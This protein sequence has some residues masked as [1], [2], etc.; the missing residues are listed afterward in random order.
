MPKYTVKT[1][2]SGLLN[3]QP[4]PGVGESVDLA[5]ELAEGMVDAGHLEK[6]AA[7]KKAAKKSETATASKANVET[8][9]GK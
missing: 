3:G 1:P 5:D 2:M 6:K 4:W 9:K 8:R 7:A